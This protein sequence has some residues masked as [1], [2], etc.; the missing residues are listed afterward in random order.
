MAF[1]ILYSLLLIFM[2]DKTCHIIVKIT[3]EHPL[4]CLLIEEN[5]KYVI[6]CFF[7]QIL[8]IL[9]VIVYIKMII[10]IDFKGALDKF[11]I[12]P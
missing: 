1:V 2:S 8:I 7:C 12:I 9:C 6:W 11:N 4:R 5:R 10:V 3:Y